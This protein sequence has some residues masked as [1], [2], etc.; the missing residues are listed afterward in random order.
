MEKTES[1]YKGSDGILW[2][3]LSNVKALGGVKY[4]HIADV[5]IDPKK[6][7]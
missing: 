4:R 1:Q 7:C 5:K 2:P 3:H 6:I